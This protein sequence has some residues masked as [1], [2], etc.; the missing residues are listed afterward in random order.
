[1]PT[2]YDEFGRKV[3]KPKKRR[4][5]G[6]EADAPY[7]FAVSI[8]NRETGEGAKDFWQEQK[9]KSPKGA[10]KNAS[11]N[12]LMPWYYNALSDFTPPESKPPLGLWL[13]RQNWNDLDF[14]ARPVAAKKDI[15]SHQIEE[16]EPREGYSHWNKMMFQAD[17]WSHAMDY[18]SSPPSTP[19]RYKE[20]PI[21][22]RAT[23]WAKMYASG[24]PHG[25]WEYHQP[26]Y[27]GPSSVLPFFDIA[28]T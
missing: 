3:E 21:D 23:T 19:Q 12:L 14:V 24:V 20:E 10:M 25:A 26:S 28:E 5:S 17:S 8:V 4:W 22:E 16:G 13:E 1:M 6:Y 2:E 11:K 7:T 27:H 9:L 18:V 15:D